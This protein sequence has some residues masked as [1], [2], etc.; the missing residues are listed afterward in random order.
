MRSRTIVTI[1]ALA[2]TALPGIAAHEAPPEGCRETGTHAE[3]EE[4]RLICTEANYFHCAGDLKLQNAEIIA[5]SNIPSWDTTPPAGSVTAGEGCGTYETLLTSGDNPYNGMDGI[6]EGTFTGNLESFTVEV[7]KIDTG[8]S[9]VDDTEA[10]LLWIRIDGVDV[11][12]RQADGT[13]MAAERSSTGASI[14]YTF[15]VTGL[16]G[17]NLERGAG[18]IERTITIGVRSFAN[19]QGAWVWDTTEVP[20]GVTFNPASPAGTLVFPG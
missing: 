2:V 7:H 5:N 14:K 1:V 11:V 6:W 4:P 20:A 9:R 13:P 3:G 8:T 19:N 15:T 12:A 18:T 10:A 17:Y 16:Q